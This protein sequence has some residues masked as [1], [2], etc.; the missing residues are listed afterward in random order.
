[1]ELRMRKEDWLFLVACLGIGILAVEAF[2]WGR[3][4]ISYFVFIA[5]FYSVFFWR[6]RGFQ[7]RHQ[8]LGWL[9]L[10]AIWLLSASYF[11]FDSDVFYGLNILAIPAL[12][13]FHIALIT[14]PK[15]AHWA[16]PVFLIYILKRIG[17]SIAYNTAVARLFGRIAIRKTGGGK[18]VVAKKVLI[19][20]V[21]SLPVLAVVLNLLISAD[22]QF[23]RILS[24]FPD[25]FSIDGEMVFRIVASL[26]YTFAFFGYLQINL[27]RRLEIQQ[28]KSGGPSGVV[29]PVTALTVLIILDAVYVLFVAVQFKYFFS[30]TLGEEFTYAEY[31]RRGFFELVFVSLIN[32][33]VT[34]FVLTFSKIGGQRLWRTVQGALSILV[35]ATGV[36]LTSA[37]MRLMMYEAA[38]GFTFTRVLVHSFMI[39]LLVIFCYTF[40]KIWLA[41]LS[42]LHFYF[43]SALVFYTAINI[44][45]V[46]KIVVE[47][48]L[49]RFEETGKIDLHYLAYMSDA[50]TLGLIKLYRE[51][52][53]TPGLRGLLLEKKKSLPESERWQSYNLTREKAKEALKQLQFD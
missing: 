14:G 27:K 3:I 40:A 43:I 17:A 12:V 6:F 16:H 33:S 21:I 31:A 1:M 38:Y 37:F 9:V 25:W 29:D 15:Q 46:D 26:I 50:G 42:L 5:A 19:G 28:L 41:R 45:G 30:G 51:Q 20:A 53:E 35:V 52:P 7:F 48:N 39:F 4:G 18:G 32:L 23:E 36:I 22:S 34:I 49:D 11:L 24:G 8:R 44:V 10:G 47:R 2:T 13:V